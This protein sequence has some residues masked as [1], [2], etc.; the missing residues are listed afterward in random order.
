MSR[1]RQRQEAYR[2]YACAL[3]ASGRYGTAMSSVSADQLNTQIVT[4]ALAWAHSEFE[5][6][7]P[8]W[9]RRWRKVWRFIWPSRGLE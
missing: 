7:E 1:R 6:F 3:I 2:A 8:A 4:V 9:R 5:Q